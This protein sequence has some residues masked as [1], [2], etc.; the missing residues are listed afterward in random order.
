MC[1]FTFGNFALGF[2]ISAHFEPLNTEPPFDRPTFRLT[3][4]KLKVIST[5]D[6][7]AVNVKKRTELG[8]SS[9]VKGF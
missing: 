6:N 7:R 1:F 4:A 2:E 3:M 9:L 5:N 8:N